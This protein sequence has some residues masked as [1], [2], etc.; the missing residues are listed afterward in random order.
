MKKTRR[1]GG[2]FLQPLLAATGIV[3]DSPIFFSVVALLLIILLIGGDTVG[4]RCST[5][6]KVCD[7]GQGSYR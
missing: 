7:L 2:K 5:F 3:V 4:D 6:V 1:S